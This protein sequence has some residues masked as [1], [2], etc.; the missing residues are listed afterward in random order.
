MAKLSRDQAPEGNLHPRETLYVQ[1]DLSLINSELQLPC[2]GLSSFAVDVRGVYTTGRFVVE[3]TVDGTNWDAVPIRPYN[4][5][6]VTYLL[7]PAAAAQGIWVGRPGPFRTIRVR[8]SVASTAAPATVTITGSTGILDDT[9]QNFIT[10]V[11]ATAVGAAGAAVTLTVAAP[12]AGL[13]Q[14]ITYLRITRF[15][16]AALVAAAAPVTV[17]TTNIPGAIAFTFPADAALQGTTSVYQED[18]NLPVAA[19]A[20]NLAVTVV[21]PAT[22]NVIWRVSMGYYVAP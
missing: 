7:N 11:L 18:F 9:L 12:G 8:M 21:C 20:Q 10:P 17:T 4:Q 5:A 3:G 2:D 6:S 15:A 1:G 22:T 19:S 13:R 14:Y 16:A